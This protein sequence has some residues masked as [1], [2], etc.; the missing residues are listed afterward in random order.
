MGGGDETKNLILAAVLSM[1]V[2]FGWFALFPPAPPPEDV[3]NPE[4]QSADGS[5]PVPGAEVVQR[6]PAVAQTREGAIGESDRIEITSPSIYGTLRL[7]GARI[8]DLHLG[9]YRET[10][11]PGADTVI[12]LNPEGGPD[13]YYIDYGWVRTEGSD[14]GPLP[15]EDTLWQVESGDKLT[16]ET[17]VTL[18]WDNGQGLVFRRQIELDDKYLFTV[19]QSVENKTGE[20]VSIAPFGKI[21]RL[22]G[23]AS[24][25]LW[26]LHEGAVAQADDEL[27][28]ISYGDLQDLP[29]NPSQTGL[30]EPFRVEQNGWMG[31]TDKY[32]MTTMIP[33]AGVGFDGFYQTFVRGPVPE[34]QGLMRMNV[35]SVAAGSSS[36]V[37]TRLFAGAKEFYTLRDYEE[38]YAT[39]DFVNAIDWGW[40]YFLTK[41]I[42]QLLAWINSIIGN[43]GW[44]IIVLTLIIKAILFPLA[45]KS[46]VSMSKMKMLQPEMEKLKE[47]CG[48]DRQKMQQ[49]MM[50]LYKKEKVNPASG[51]RSSCR[52]RFSSRSTRC[53]SSPSKCAT[54]RSLAGSPIFRRPIRLRS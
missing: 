54:R 1:L 12:L 46:Y 3:P 42:F 17:P 29:P 14:P 40:F 36:E 47:R 2:V 15:K 49:E 8:D 11:D 6:A 25:S 51:C 21:V 39:K 35:V 50:A 32:W 33:E 52:S 7:E 48:D 18:V 31:F 34:Y 37:T 4:A 41:P 45:W 43:M 38:Q 24:T 30:I 20:A 16:P 23:E 44:S 22:G 5:V 26:I 28:E 53:C 19:T 13:P 9:D 10:L 27:K